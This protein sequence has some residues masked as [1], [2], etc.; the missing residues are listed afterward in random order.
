[1]VVSVNQKNKTV[2]VTH[3][4]SA[5]FKY[6]PK[7]DTT[8]SSKYA[9]NTRNCSWGVNQ[10]KSYSLLKSGGYQGYS[11]GPLKTNVKEKVASPSVSAAN[12]DYGQKITLSCKTSGAAIYYTPDGKDPSGRTKINYDPGVL[13]PS[14]AEEAPGAVPGSIRFDLAFEPALAVSGETQIR[15]YTFLRS[16]VN[17]KQVDPP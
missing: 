9:M 11:Y 4:S 3:Q 13:T 10:V 2:T 8:G 5:Y 1:M 16:V 14:V 7:T 6:D 15:E 12:T 17:K